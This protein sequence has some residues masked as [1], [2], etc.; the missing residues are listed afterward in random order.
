MKNKTG[1]EF[2]QMKKR[3]WL[4]LLLAA[5][6]VLAGCQAALSADETDTAAVEAQDNMGLAGTSWVMSSI[7][8]DI[9]AS[10]TTVWMEFGTDGSVTGSDGCNNFATTYVQSNNELTIAQPA[11]STLIA[12]EAIVMNQGASVMDALAST[13]SFKAIGNQL[14]LMNGSEILATFVALSQDLADTSWDVIS[15]NNG[16]E[17]VVGLLLDTEITANFGVDGMVSGNAGCNNYFAGYTVDGENLSIEMPAST[18]MFCSEPPGVMEQENEFLAALQSAATYSVQGDQLMMRTADDQLALIMVRRHEV[19]LPEPEPSVPWGRVTAPAGVNVRSGPGVNFPVIGHAAFNDEGEIVG[20]DAASTWWAVA[21][22]SLQ[23]GMGWISADFMIAVDAGDVPV[24]QIAPPPVVVPPTAVAPAVPTPVPPATATPTA[25]ISF[26]A[27][28]TTIDQGQCTTLEWNAQNVQA[29]WVYPQ[30]QQ[31]N[32][33]PRSLQGSELV[34]PPTTTTYEMRVLRRDGGV[35]TRQV[36]ITVN[37]TAEP[38][39]SF[40][41]DSTTINQ[42]ECTRI[43]W[44]TENV[45]AVWVYPQGESFERYPRVGNDSERVCPTQTTTYEMRVQLLDGS[46]VFRQVTVNVNA[47]TP[48]P[49]PNNPLMGG[50]WN[51]V[52][53]NNGSGINTLIQGTEITMAFG[54]NGRLTGSA[55]CNSYNGTYTVNGNRLTVSDVGSGM[56]MCTEPSGVMEQEQAFILALQYS[57]SFQVDGTQLRIENQSGNLSIIADR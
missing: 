3:L 21:T 42:G 12:C 25:S 44:S 55:G 14:I 22:P 28:P 52:Q 45:Q 56:M 6:M 46:T 57:S 9:P 20:R 23:N 36:T 35:D 33:Y 38:Q 32:R 41:A 8:G 15:Y 31:Y 48:T 47:P 40:W 24:I 50:T 27:N 19:D 39:I 7:D 49:A 34:C 1:K 16:R 30:G 2:N 51:V 10:G 26:G 18:F 53:F 5:V 54:S 29:V 43:R 4:F 13:T 11:A 37:A 17:A